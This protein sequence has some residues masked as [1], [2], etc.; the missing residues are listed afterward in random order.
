MCVVAATV[1]HLTGQAVKFKII[2]PLFSYTTSFSS[3]ETVSISSNIKIHHERGT[4]V[5]VIVLQKQNE[6][7]CPLKQGPTRNSRE[8][9]EASKANCLERQDI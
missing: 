5:T 6:L 1:Y 7:N 8:S 3:Y 4:S 2:E 9:E